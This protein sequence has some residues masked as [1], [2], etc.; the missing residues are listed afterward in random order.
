MTTLT[1]DLEAIVANW[2]LLAGRH[3]GQTAA[4]LKADAYGLGAARVGARLYAEG[5]RHFFVAYPSEGEA[6]RMHVPGAMIGVLNGLFAEQAGLYSAL[7]LAPVLGNAGEIAAWQAHARGLG[8]KL[9]ALLHIDTGMNRL[10]LSPTELAR[11]RAHPQDLDGIDLLYVMTH[12]VNAEVPGDPR[13]AAQ[14][15][16]FAA[17]CDGLPRLPRSIAN[18]SGIF[19]GAAYHSD[20][21]RPG[22]ALYGINP[23][24]GLHNPMRPAMRLT[25]R[26]L[27]LRD[28]APGEPVGYNGIWTAARPTSVATV[29][30]GYADGYHRALSNHAFGAFDGARLP[31]IGRVSMDLATFDATGH[32]ALRVGS[33]LELIGPSIPPDEV[34]GWAGTNGYEILTSLATRSPRIYAAL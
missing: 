10:G 9:P 31:L 16:R 5:V 13:N 34:A 8:R 24:P 18:S 1:I 21:A 28:I 7:D 29:S 20:L 26:V 32:P 30:V 22:A 4:V 11:L 17:A 27:Q 15:S 23:T 19:L 2:R 25:G 3:P 12:L 14:L 33:E 6:L